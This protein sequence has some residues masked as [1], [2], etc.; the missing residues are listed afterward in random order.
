MHA[1]RV[2]PAATKPLPESFQ[3]AV[4]GGGRAER[5][6]VIVTVAE[7]FAARSV[8]AGNRAGG[9]ELSDA[10]AH[11]HP[12]VSRMLP[13]GDPRDRRSRRYA[14]GRRWVKLRTWRCQ[15]T[16]PSRSARSRCADRKL[17]RSPE[18]IGGAD[19]GVTCRY[20]VVTMSSG[21]ASCTVVPPGP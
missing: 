15:L 3:E 19:A 14:P 16:Y 2:K 9:G 8:G 5:G 10:F 12:V 18:T 6:G 7:S 11:V 4:D 1:D 20:G 17:V 13:S 21:I